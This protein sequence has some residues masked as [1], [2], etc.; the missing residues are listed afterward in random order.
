MGRRSI[1]ATESIESAIRFIRRQ[2]VMLDADL[3]ALYGVSTKYLNQAVGRNRSRFPADFAFQ[4]T[5]EEWSVLRLQI[6]TSSLHG[7]RRFRPFVFTEQG[8]AM[9]SSVLNSN[10]AI[11]VNVEIMRA[12]V[13]L[14][15]TLAMHSE[16]ARKLAE[17][18]RRVGDHDEQFVAVI[19]AIRELMEPPPSPPKRRIGFL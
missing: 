9:L 8:V 11:R 18:E 14:R 12:F 3:A 10:R 15:S 17:L 6:A 19:H 5:T 1:V 16:L 13:R 2:R 4:L 7:G